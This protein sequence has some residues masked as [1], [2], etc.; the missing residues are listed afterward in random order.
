[1]GWLG[2][3]LKEIPLSVIQQQKIAHMEAEYADMKAEKASLKD[4]LR[5]ANAEIAK[6]KKQVEQLAHDVSNL[7]DVETRILSALADSEIDPVPSSLIFILDLHRERFNYAIERLIEL[8]FVHKSPLW[9]DE[10]SY[11]LAQKG[12]G[13]LIRNN[14]I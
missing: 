4:D 9:E 2:D 7:D 6:L 11:S 12:R 1:M 14:L 5:Q 13:Y 8:D 3:L 10:P